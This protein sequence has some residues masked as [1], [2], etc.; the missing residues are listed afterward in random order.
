MAEEKLLEKAKQPA[1][2]AKRNLEFERSVTSPGIP[3][4]LGN[5]KVVLQKSAKAKEKVLEKA[6]Q[7]TDSTKQNLD[8]DKKGTMP[9]S[10]D[11]YIRPFASS[12]RSFDQGSRKHVRN[13]RA[14]LR[15]E[16]ESERSGCENERE[17]D[18]YSWLV[19]TRSL[20]CCSL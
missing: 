18:V 9:V 13:S 5:L 12:S 17:E 3:G 11:Q 1:D 8:F 2:S 10:L 7:P 16:S 14:A 20:F 6:N 19:S 15:T 4:K